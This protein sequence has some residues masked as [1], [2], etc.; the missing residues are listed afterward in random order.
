M[1]G[2]LMLDQNLADH[3][4]LRGREQAHQIE[5]L[6][7]LLHRQGGDA[8]PGRAFPG[9]PAGHFDNFHGGRRRA[10]RP[11]QPQRRAGGQVKPSCT[12]LPA[13]PS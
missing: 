10:R 11:F 8:G 5:A 13:T 1:K 7:Q 9:D 2:A 12:G 4:R 3:G 6:W